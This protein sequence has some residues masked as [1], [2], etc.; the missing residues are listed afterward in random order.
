MKI[1]QNHPERVRERYAKRTH[2]T[3]SH[4]CFVFL[5][6]QVISTVQF[7]T[8]SFLFLPLFYCVAL[9][10]CAHGCN[11][12]FI[13]LVVAYTSFRVHENYKKY[14]FSEKFSVSY[15][16]SS[17]CF[18]LIMQSSIIYSGT[19]SII[20]IACSSVSAVLRY[21]K[22]IIGWLKMKSYE[23]II[24]VYTATVRPTGVHILRGIR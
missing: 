6:S 22:H 16:F 4:S 23:I 2:N 12:S 1:R 18:D 3:V 10:K 13:F 15:R 21:S 9:A 19:F 17:D 24:F 7:S 11:V 8:L 14:T 5:Q 20:C